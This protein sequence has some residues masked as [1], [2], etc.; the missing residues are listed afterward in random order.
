MDKMTNLE[1]KTELLE[2]SESRSGHP[3]KPV[4]GPKSGFQRLFG[5]S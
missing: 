1:I 5:N 2:K 3:K 4:F